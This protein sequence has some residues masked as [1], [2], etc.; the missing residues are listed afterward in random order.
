MTQRESGEDKYVTLSVIAKQGTYA[1]KDVTMSINGKNYQAKLNGGS[2]DV[3]LKRDDTS[4]YTVKA[5]VT[6]EAYYTA[7]YDRSLTADQD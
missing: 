6:D 4:S 3:T 2:W 5:T 1:I 7:T